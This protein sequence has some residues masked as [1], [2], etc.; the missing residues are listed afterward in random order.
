[1]LM[2]IIIHLVLS[3]DG[4]EG[5]EGGDV[6]GDDSDHVAAKPGNQEIRSLDI[7]LLRRR[8]TEFPWKRLPCF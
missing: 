5:D 7:G 1:M 8:R 6:A 4:E 2:L 3:V